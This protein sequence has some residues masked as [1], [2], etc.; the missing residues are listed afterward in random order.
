MPA[1]ENQGQQDEDQELKF[2]V[3]LGYVVNER[4]P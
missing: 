1:S 4:L 2:K 3:I